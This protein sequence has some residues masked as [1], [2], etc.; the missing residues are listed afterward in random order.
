VA[1]VSRWLVTH[2]PSLLLLV[3]LVVSIAGAAILVQRVVR[4]RFPALAGDDHND[5]TRFTYGFIGF[6]YAFFIGFVVSNM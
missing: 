1:N 4:K 3:L 5:V 2:I 6:V